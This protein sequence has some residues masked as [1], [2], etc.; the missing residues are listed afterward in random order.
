MLMF[1]D[2]DSDVLLL[3]KKVTHT[4]WFHLCKMSRTGKF[5]ETESQLVSGCQ[6]RV[7]EGWGGGME[8]EGGVREWLGDRKNGC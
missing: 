8:R 1:P 7:G 6:G 2:L 4:V 5:V 3:K